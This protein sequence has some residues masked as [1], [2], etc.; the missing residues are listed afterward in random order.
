MSVCL[1][2]KHFIMTL[3]SERDYS[4]GRDKLFREQIVTIGD[5]EEFRALLLKDLGKMM[6]Q[7]NVNT[8]KK[9]LRTYEVKEML[10]VS[11]GT[12][13]NLRNNGHLPFTKVGGIIFYESREVT[14]MLGKNSLPSRLE[15]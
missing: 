8:G 2:L 14:K 15:R 10:G 7:N 9:W 5:L 4:Y 11:Q 12:L 13:Q 3:K 1:T 6:D